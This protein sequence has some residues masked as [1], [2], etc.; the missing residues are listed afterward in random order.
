M[1]KTDKLNDQVKAQIDSIARIDEGL[2]SPIW[3]KLVQGR[4]KKQLKK[5]QK[6]PAMRDALK[7][8]DKSLEDFESAL[9]THHDIVLKG[10]ED[11][12]KGDKDYKSFND[13]VKFYKS[14]G[15]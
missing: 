2:F 6:D 14:I 11:S 1:A 7:R 5:F 8:L 9:E 3:K 10:L 12:A 4:L 15:L 13:K